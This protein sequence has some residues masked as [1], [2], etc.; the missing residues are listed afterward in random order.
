M[1]SDEKVIDGSSL[2][3][4]LRIAFTSLSYNESYLNDINTFPVSDSDTGTNMRQSF[5]KGL[6]ATDE[7]QNAGDLLFK[8][9][10]SMSLDSRGNSGFILS[11]YFI[12]LSEYLKGKESISIEDFKNAIVHAYKIAYAAVVNPALRQIQIPEFVYRR[13]AGDRTIASTRTAVF[14]RGQGIHYPGRSSQPDGERA[15]HPLRQSWGT[16]VGKSTPLFSRAA[17]YRMPN[18]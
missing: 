10:H 1:I 8:F 12:G 14:R 11:Q 9:A 17:C 5:H 4:M 3:N 16:E 6:V 18:D 13:N 15:R 7:K 2:Y